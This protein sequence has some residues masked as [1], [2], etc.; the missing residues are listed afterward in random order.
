MTLH[1]KLIT[2]SAPQHLRLIMQKSNGQK[3]SKETCIYTY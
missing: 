3:V 2:D 1:T